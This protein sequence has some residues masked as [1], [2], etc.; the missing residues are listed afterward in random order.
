MWVMMFL[1]CTNVSLSCEFM[2]WQKILHCTN[3][4]NHATCTY[5]S[6]LDTNDR[7]DD[8]RSRTKKEENSNNNN[9]TML[10]N[11]LKDGGSEFSR[12]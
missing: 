4:I 3:S 10:A 9:T 7:T 12:K 2:S 11:E 6:E 8:S 5:F 1:F